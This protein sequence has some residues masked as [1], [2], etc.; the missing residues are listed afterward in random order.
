MIPV[1]TE[2]GIFALYLLLVLL[3]GVAAARFTEH[4]PDDF[5]LADRTVGTY[6]LGLTFVA[7]VLSAFTV[8]GIGG[9]VYTTGPGTFSFLAIAAVFYTVVFATVGVTL[10]EVGRDMNVVTPSEYIRRRYE[11]PELGV[12]YLAVTGIF[13]VGLIAAQLEGGG[14]ILDSLMGIPYELAIVLM[15]AF[16]LVY[17]HIAGYRGVIW[18]DTLQAIVLFG[19]LGG[20]TAYVMGTMEPNALATEAA[21]QAEGILTLGGQVGAWTPIFIMTFAL[22]FVFGVPAYPHTIQRYFS[23]NAGKT[24]RRSGFVFAIIAVPTYFFGTV[25]GMWAPSVIAEPP[26]PDWVIPLLVDTLMHPIVFGIF[27]ASAIA[28]IMST[29]DSTALTMSSMISRDV[30]VPFVDPDATERRQVRVT[31][32]LLVAVIVFAFALA[33]LR[34]AG[35]F[36]LVAFAVVGL[37]TTSAPV[38]FGA[39]WDRATAWGAAVSLVVGPGLLILFELG[40][41]PAHPLGIYHGF[42]SLFASYLAFAVVSLVTETPTR[43]SI[44]DHSRSFLSEAD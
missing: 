7:T 36:Q 1:T 21:G 41:L 44:R 32:A 3:V 18:S 11:S 25:L 14:V 24:V 27:M 39:Y 35:I 34:P 19:T 17:I 23:G 30:Y 10:Y 43:E 4:T 5:Y 9:N 15:A 38:F 22:A 20:V 28:A 16:M 33:W 42:T 31:Q 8:L 6:I 12:L 13:M 29:A 37:G 40:F 26:E 2:Q